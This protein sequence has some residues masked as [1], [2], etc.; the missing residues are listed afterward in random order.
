MFI[1]L[2]DLARRNFTIGEISADLAYSSM[3]HAAY[4]E[5]HGIENF[6]PFN[7]GVTGTD[8][9]STDVWRRMYHYF[10]LNRSEFIQRYMKRSNVETTFHMLKNKYGS[11]LN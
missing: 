2:V 4:T 6:I 5:L 9:N 3:K 10:N 11:T 8:I 7:D 1:P